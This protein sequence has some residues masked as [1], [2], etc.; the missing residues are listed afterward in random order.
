MGLT[1]RLWVVESRVHAACARVRVR[2]AAVTYVLSMY[3]VTSH[4]YERDRYTRPDVVHSSLAL[5]REIDEK[6]KYFR[7]VFRLIFLL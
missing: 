4:R 5:A 6:M 2:P 3:Y 1:Y 7:E